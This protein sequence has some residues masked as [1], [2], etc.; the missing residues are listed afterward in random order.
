MRTTV[1]SPIDP[2]NALLRIVL[3]VSKEIVQVT[4]PKRLHHTVVATSLGMVKVTA[5]LVGQLI[6]AGRVHGRHLMPQV[7]AFAP[8]GQR[9]C[10]M[11][12]CCPFPERLMVQKRDHGSLKM[13][14]VRC[15]L[16]NKS[17]VRQGVRILRQV[18]QRLVKNCPKTFLAAQLKNIAKFRIHQ[19]ALGLWQ[20][21]PQAK[22]RLRFRLGKR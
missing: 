2:L 7:F 8:V 17:A 12:T 5:N 21:Q 22:Q 6:N 11:E 10:M 3:R 16:V 4:A 14:S 19:I 13:V 15:Q 18:E 20:I 1:K 9:V